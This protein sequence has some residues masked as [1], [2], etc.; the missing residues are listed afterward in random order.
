[1]LNSQQQV[2]FESMQQQRKDKYKER[3]GNKHKTPE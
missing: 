1:V 2:K 3:K